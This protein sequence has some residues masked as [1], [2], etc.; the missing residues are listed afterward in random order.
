[1][2]QRFA[3]NDAVDSPLSPVAPTFAWSLTVAILLTVAGLFALIVP[4]VS[5][6]AITLIAG[7]FLT[8]VGV[9]HFLFAWKTHSS[10][11]VLWEVL[12]G[13]LYLISGIYFIFHPIAG[14]ASLTLLLVAYF[15]V[16]GILMVI[17]YF[18]LQPRHGSGWLLFDGI[19]NLVLAI[20]IWRSWP[21]SA[22]WVIGTLVGISLVFTGFSRL[23]LTLN[24]RSALRA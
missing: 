23:M 11:G 9:L 5:G 12:L 10:S 2:Y 15:A 7:W 21:F 18:Q 6:V 4:I 8:V 13:V 3:M 16:K 22:T 17:H 19:V 24:A 20:I 1:M 14:L